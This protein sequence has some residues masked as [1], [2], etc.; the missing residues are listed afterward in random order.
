MRA[1]L[2]SSSAMVVAVALVAGSCGGGSDGTQAEPQA[3][4]AVFSAAEP[5]PSSPCSR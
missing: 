2:E 4:D 5:R 1:K 3:N